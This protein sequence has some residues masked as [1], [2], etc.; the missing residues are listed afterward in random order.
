MNSRIKKVIIGTTIASSI[1][2]FTIS[3]SFANF[4]Q[5]KVVAG[6]TLWKISQQY[7][8][9]LDELYK[10]NPKFVSNSSLL[11][12]DVVNVPSKV[13]T[14][15]VK[16]GDTPWTIS[17]SFDITLQQFMSFNNLKDGQHIYPGD[18]VIIPQKISSNQNNNSNTQS[19]INYTV[20]S[21]DTPWTIS[22]AYK[23]SMNDLLS[24]NGL[25]QKDFVYPGQVLKIPSQ[26][27]QSQVQNPPIQ[28]NPTMPPPNT[29]TPQKTFITHT[30]VSGDDL[31]KI[32]IRYGIPFSELL[33]VNGFKENHIVYIGDKINIPV[34]NIPVKPTK[35]AQFGELL[36]WWTEAQY[37]VPINKT[38]K[39]IDFNTGKEWFAKRTIGANHADCEP[40]TA[41]DAAI[42]KEVWGGNFSWARRP[43]IIEVDGRRLAASASSLPHDI[44]YITNNN[45]NG[46]FDLYFLNSTRHVD[47]KGDPE[48]QKN[49]LMA[50]GN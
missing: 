5:H 41:K 43:V 7:E 2:S 28:H 37:V 16:T 9:S 15:T 4:T 46:H 25:T 17:N 27:Q 32:S 23:I 40:L 30:V 33:Q 13:V 34:Y 10:I 24:F 22:N 50:A 31:W 20:K 11:V 19:N 29:S 47:G 48:H 35:G 42:M 49:L 26:T 18:R 12:G 39:I 36:D 21:G 44:Q 3:N 45:F 6:D 8:T 1:F 38:F 14:Y